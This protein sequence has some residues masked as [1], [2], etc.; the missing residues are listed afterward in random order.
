[1]ILRLDK[2]LPGKYDFS[3]QTRKV[4]AHNQPVRVHTRLEDQF[5]RKILCSR[6]SSC[7][8]LTFSN[9]LFFIQ[10]IKQSIN[11]VVSSI[12]HDSL[13]KF[14]QVL[15]PTL[16]EI[17]RFGREELVETILELSVVVE[18]NSAQIVGERAEEVVLRW[19][20][21]RRVGRMWKN[22]PVEFLN[23][24]F[25]HVCSVWSGV[26]MLKNYSMSARAFL[27]DCFIQT[28]KLLTITLSSDDQVPLKQ[29]I[30]DNPLHIPP[31]A[32]HGR[33]ER[34]VSFMSKLPCLKRVNL[35]WAVIS[36]IESSP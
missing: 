34:G 28:T 17:H 33:P 3:F 21:V 7:G 19:G 10:I 11:C 18:G 8:F 27:L 24:R 14:G 22:L 31:D 36:A 1:M 13:P 15:D 25:F 35:F 6:I 9:N 2:T 5:Y 16:G 4:K 26:V 12:T 30:I 23:G 20:K 32:Q 29:F